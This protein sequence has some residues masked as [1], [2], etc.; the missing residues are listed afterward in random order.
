MI[1]LTETQNF[2]EYNV[3]TEGS[4]KDLYI[5]GV[6]AEYGIKNK[7]GR[8]YE[9]H[10]MEPALNK[11]INEKIKTKQALG[12]LSHP[13]R[14]QVDPRMASHLIT[15][16]QLV[17][18][19]KEGQVIGKA[20]IINT[21]EGNIVRGLLESGVALG[22]STRALGQVIESK[23]A[24]MV[25]SDFI[26]GTVDIVTDPSAHS[27]WVEAVNESREW[28]VTDSGQVLEK[29]QKEIKKNHLTESKKLQLMQEF[30]KTLR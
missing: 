17:G 13:Q 1:F 5:S 28:L 3:I 25:Q 16:M 7:N 24:K 20:K 26:L 30:F 9:R 2:G 6:F 4:G 21:P 18:D 10:I 27:A 19:S 15:E 23:G 29:M 14:F 12:E 11:F 8:I 22:V